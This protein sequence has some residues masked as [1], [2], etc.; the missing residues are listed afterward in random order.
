[1]LRQLPANTKRFAYA[2]DVTNYG[3]T[4]QKR[5][6]RAPLMLVDGYSPKGTYDARFLANYAYIKLF[7]PNSTVPTALS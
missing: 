5:P 4:V 2:S 6:R 7:R 1:M 3:V